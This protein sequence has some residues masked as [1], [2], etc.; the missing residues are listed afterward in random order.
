MD[1]RTIEIV[2]DEAIAAFVKLA[3][4]AGFLAASHKE[5]GRYHEEA[6]SMAVNAMTSKIEGK[7]P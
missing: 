3:K 2:A 1:T 4:D 7:K 6:I 5:L